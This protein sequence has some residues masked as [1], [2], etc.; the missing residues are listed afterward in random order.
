[1]NDVCTYYGHSGAVLKVVIDTKTQSFFSAGLD[2]QV[3]QWGLPSLSKLA[4]AD[5]APT[6]GKAT[7]FRKQVFYGHS[8]AVWDLCVHDS[9]ELAFSAS[10]DGTVQVWNYANKSP[11]AEALYK[12]LHPSGGKAR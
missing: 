4:K 6:Y 3:M 9:R 2:S 8:D 10:A 12:I 11:D 5:G 1:M 7:H